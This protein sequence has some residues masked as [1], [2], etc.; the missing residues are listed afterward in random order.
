M[1][2]SQTIPP[3]VHSKDE[4]PCERINQEKVFQSLSPIHS[5]FDGDERIRLAKLVGLSKPPR[6]VHRYDVAARRAVSHSS[7][8]ATEKDTDSVR[9]WFGFGL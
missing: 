9:S 7:L 3:L 6:P 4:V 5:H 2:S 8:V 1:D